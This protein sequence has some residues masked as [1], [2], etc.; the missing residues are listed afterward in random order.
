[1]ALSQC[2][3]PMERLDNLFRIEFLFV[4]V[5]LI[6]IQSEGGFD[7]IL[8]AIGRTP[9][10]AK[11]NLPAASI[12]TN[13]RGNVN[14]DAFQNT[15]APSVYALGDVAGKVELTPMAIA[16]GRKLA[17]RLFGGIP[18]ARADYDFVPTV[19]FSHPVI[20]TCGLTEPRAI[21]LYGNENIKVYTSN[22]VNLFYGTFSEG[23]AGDKPITKYKV[24]CLGPDERVIGLHMI[25][26]NSDE[27]LQGF[28]VAMKMGAT[29]ADFD[30]CI[31][32]HPTS[33]E[34]LVTLV[35][36]SCPK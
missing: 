7:C 28:G 16:A 31:A 29:K 5:Y 12:A 30:R 22:F 33:A 2:I 26:M 20:G 3:F 14:V 19:V 17:D 25:G 10:T 21:E 1:M 13:N 34:E 27:I 8:T 4:I 35:P 15:S 32:I 9:L 24:I 36:W 6:L 11:L 23:N 18:D